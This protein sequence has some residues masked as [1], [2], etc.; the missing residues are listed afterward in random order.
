MS[1]P[2]VNATEREADAEA[3]RS[4]IAFEATAPLPGA[5]L[6]VVTAKPFLGA[7]RLGQEVHAVRELRD[8]WEHARPD[9]RR[10]LLERRVVEWCLPPAKRPRGRPRK[11]VTP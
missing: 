10:M 6:R 5:V 7:N 8:F 4:A 11:P 9:R 2:D 3:R 1:A